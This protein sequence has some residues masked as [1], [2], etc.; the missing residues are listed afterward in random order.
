ME[1]HDVKEK[2]LLH[3]HYDFSGHVIRP[4]RLEIA[5]H[6]TDAVKGLKPPRNITELKSLLALCSVFIVFL[7]TFARNA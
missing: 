5:S 2:Q 1:N 4:R 3:E 7:P 6:K